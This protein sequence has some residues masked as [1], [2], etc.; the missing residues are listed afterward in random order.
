MLREAA[1]WVLTP[2]DGPA[3]QLGYLAESIALEARWRRCRAAWAAHLEA[4]RRAV[5]DAAGAC[6]RRRAVA[7]LGSGPLLDVPLATLARDFDRVLL[8]DI[9]HP[10]RARGAARRFPNVFLA[11]A[12][13]AGVAEA[14]TR[15]PTRRPAIE[16]PRLP[17]NEADLDLVVSL[18]LVSQLAQAPI[19]VLRR[20]AGLDD[21]GAADLH[22]DLVRAHIDWL[23]GMAP[24]AALIGDL[25]QCWSGPDGSEVW[26]PLEGAGLPAPPDREWDWA[27]VPKGERADGRVQTNRV[28]A[29]LALDAPSRALA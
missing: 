27:I 2:A 16:P 22:R 9:V 24:R 8:V 19:G 20:H 23:A 10:W 14:L 17:C 29:Y 11:Q 15:D 1:E 5:M 18:N 13:I 28:G 3:R 6:P 25:E 4:S 7:I 21:E 12:D 26:H